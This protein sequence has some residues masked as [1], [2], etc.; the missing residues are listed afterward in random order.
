MYPFHFINEET[1][2][3]E[4]PSEAQKDPQLQEGGARIYTQSV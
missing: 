4:F 2:A 1:E 3:R